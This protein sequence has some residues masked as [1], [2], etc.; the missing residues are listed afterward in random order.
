MFYF[1]LEQNCIVKI[2]VA[3]VIT[4]ILVETIWILICILFVVYT[5]TLTSMTLEIAHTNSPS[6]L[7]DGLMST[8]SA[9][10]GCTSSRIEFTSKSSF[11]YSFLQLSQSSF[12]FPFTIAKKFFRLVLGFFFLFL[13]CTKWTF[14]LF[15]QD[16]YI[17]FLPLCT[18]ST[19]NCRGLLN[20]R[21]HTSIST[22]SHIHYSYKSSQWRKK[23]NTFLSPAFLSLSW[24]TLFSKV[25]D[26][27]PS[28][29]PSHQP[30][31]S[32]LSSH[33]YR[34]QLSCCTPYY[35]CCHMF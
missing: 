1:N 28:K 22:T 23:H 2:T 10:N 13:K 4:S 14:L 29:V 6:S 18:A 9:N 27:S 20:N 11:F 21:W 33:Y 5:C 17:L 25:R 16:L 26:V 30:A 12:K 15:H 7:F 8:N 19:L 31:S 24:Y 32:K 34:Y 3:N 35:W